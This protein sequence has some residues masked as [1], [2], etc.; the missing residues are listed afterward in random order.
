MQRGSVGRIERYREWNSAL[1]E[2]VYPQQDDPSPAYMSLGEE[3]R[4]AIATALGFETKDFDSE[5]AE[6]LRGVLD[7]RSSGPTELFQPINEELSRW[8]TAD[9]S[10]RGAPPV[11]PLLALLAVAANR[12]ATSDGMAENNFYG[13]VKELLDYSDE[14]HRFE[15]GYRRYSERYWGAL[16]KWLE[17]QDG[18]HGLPTAMAVGYR[19]VGLPI[20]QILVRETDREKLPLFF[21]EAGFPPGAVV[22]PQE[23]EAA[24]SGWIESENGRVSPALRR[25]WSTKSAKSRILES[26]STVLATWN[27][28]VAHQDGDD[29]SL[30]VSLALNIGLFPRPRVDFS[31]I[32]Y[33][34]K[35]DEPQDGEIKTVHGWESVGLVPFSAGI[36]R[37]GDQST[38][39]NRTLLEGVLE[40]RGAGS[41]RVTVRRPR[42]I[43]VFRR[44]EHAGAF[45]EAKQTMLGEDI[46]VVVRSDD[47]LLGTVKDILSKCARAGWDT[48]P[49]EY[50]GLP[51]GWT[52]FHKVQILAHPGALIPERM[53]M[54]LQALTPLTR[55]QILVSGGFSLP[56]SARSSWHRDRLPEV[57]VVSDD[58]AGFGVK[59]FDLS[60]SA[61]DGDGSLLLLESRKNEAGALVIALA[62]EELEDGN[63]RLEFTSASSAQTTVPLTIRVRSGDT[64]DEKQLDKFKP[65]NQFLDDPLSVLCASEV[66]G[67]TSIFGGTLE[68]PDAVEP[69]AASVPPE[70]HWRTTRSERQ[71]LTLS[72]PSVPP[73]SCVYTGAHK[74]R[75]EEAPLSKDGKP[76]VRYTHGVCVRCGLERRYLTNIHQVKKRQ[77][78]QPVSPEVR[79]S[80]L[81]N[82]SAV[83]GSEEGLPWDIVLDGFFRCGAGNASTFERLSS[84]LEPSALMMHH[85]TRTLSSLGYVELMRD[86]ES[87][88]LT[89]WEVSPTALIPT[90]RGWFLC[91]YWPKALIR[92]QEKADPTLK[93]EW[94][95][96]QEAPASRYFNHFPS[97]ALK[98]VVEG[99]DALS[100]AVQLPKL[101]EVIAALPRVPAPVRATGVSVFDPASAKWQ[102]ADCMTLVGGYRMRGFATMD[103][104]RNQDDLE[105]R[106]MAVSTVHL[107]KHAAALLWGRKPLVAYDGRAHTLS[108]PLGGNLPG[109][110][111]R[112]VVLASGLAPVIRSGSV[113]YLDV[114]PELAGHI[115][116]LLSH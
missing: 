82:I 64:I 105:R 53:A 22:S 21:L 79:A 66:V 34:K 2:A 63:Y 111:E 68:N 73:E 69:Y 96:Q 36:V 44:V 9:S 43:M 60:D 115:A 35:A 20:S 38:F 56:G 78:K 16:E 100:I 107:S 98:G 116:Y 42:R 25:L 28:H 94:I 90:P 13:R 32:M 47:H 17:E 7:P 109:L 18:S 50:G 57:R 45:L 48:Y 71:K 41:E 4:S 46:L 10:E 86:R 72:I 49:A 65:I 61:S 89:G 97:E 54:D 112:A 33:T 80:S 95:D 51:P 113:H 87:L 74:I 108:V 92:A 1:A 84:F 27:G 15:N 81:G 8:R 39:D 59:L 62:E 77:P 106:T 88:Q 83:G 55:S 11:L 58:P 23:L 24:L 6:C 31:P 19:H 102:D 52:L 29:A 103:L 37:I 3:Q 14:K 26:V 67:E 101:S 93:V 5:L 91:G 104:L 85:L 40:V 30:E 70:P 110:Y 114:S 75:V 76:L 12:M 99:V